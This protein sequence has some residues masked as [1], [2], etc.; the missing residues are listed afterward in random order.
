MTITRKEKVMIFI[1]IIFLLVGGIYSLG[2]MNQ[3][4]AK[5]ETEAQITDVNS[6]I[7]AQKTRLSQ[8]DASVRSKLQAQINANTEELEKLS[9][10]GVDVNAEVQS[11]N[12]PGLSDN[13]DVAEFI[14][15]YFAENKLEVPQLTVNSPTTSS[16]R[17]VYRVTTNYTCTDSNDLYLFIDKVAQ[18]VSYNITGLTILDVY[19]MD[20]NAA[21][22]SGAITLTITYLNIES[23]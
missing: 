6:E 3:N 7:T 4:S 17:I 9:S 2:I 11:G 21:G 5:E 19:D 23:A 10:P 12:L 13:I 22:V 1:L 18:H 16:G 15:N 8:V 14:S 20:G